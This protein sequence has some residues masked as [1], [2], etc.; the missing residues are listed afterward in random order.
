MDMQNISLITLAWELY[1]S[2]IP[3]LQIA[4][5][6]HKNR[7]TIHLWIKGIKLYGLMEFLDL[8]EQA[9]KGRRT[10]RK[11]SSLVKRY[12]WNIREREENCCGQKIQ[13]FLE[14]EHHLH[15]SVPKIY[16][17][18]AEKYVIRS[19]WKKN[20]ERGPVPHPE[21][22]REVVQMDTVDFGGLFAFTGI[23]C[24]SREADVL[25][26]PALTSS[27]GHRFLEQSM[28]RRFDGHVGL[29]Q[30]DGGP[31]FKDEFAGHVLE[32]CDRHRISRPYKKNEQAFIESFNRTLRKECLGWQKYNQDQLVFC[33]KLVESFLERYH[34]HR[35]HM[36]LGMKPPLTRQPD[37]RIFK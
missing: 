35:P 27:F 4:R 5:D 13:Y 18:L 37:C 28:D 10:P 9:K 3:Q 21:R 12:I 20:L 16:Q 29:I 32:Y 1:R 23:D 7:D 31:E 19:K 22:P 24:S 34:Y 2:N 36:G 30:N 6:I 26:A 11:A 33:T 14:R 8:Y 15:L 17:V 25:M